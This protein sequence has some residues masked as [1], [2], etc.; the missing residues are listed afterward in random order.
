MELLNSE[1][2]GTS[3]G[4]DRE[5][6]SVQYLES[7]TP[8]TRN[9]AQVQ[10]PIQSETLSIGSDGNY[11]VLKNSNFTGKLCF[12]GAARI[13]CQVAGEILGTDVIIVAQDALVTGRV[14]AASVLIEG[15]ITADV[16]ASER[17]EILPSATVLGN[18]TAPAM[19]VHEGATVE[20]HFTMSNGRQGHDPG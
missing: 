8:A 16:I 19:M 17:I 3:E 10:R 15:R 14:R 6:R 4:G 5:S 18:L 11:C 20:G 2:C 1:P 9:G 13:E 7:A 12:E